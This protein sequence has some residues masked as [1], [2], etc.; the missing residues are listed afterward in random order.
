M[1]NVAANPPNGFAFQSRNREAF[2]FKFS[3][4]FIV[5]MIHISFNLVIERLFISR[6]NAEVG[7]RPLGFLF[8]SRNREAF[9]FKCRLLD[10]S[11][12]KYLKFQSRNR[13]A[14]HFKTRKLPT[15]RWNDCAFQSR[16]REAFHFKYQVL[17]VKSSCLLRFNL[18]IERLF[19]S[20]LYV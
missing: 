6:Q 20:R 1:G 11:H 3:I 14:F 4:G 5:V 10:G 16:N 7:A 19:I 18:V 8:Q 12:T 13:E 9:H 15:R 17:T 2:H